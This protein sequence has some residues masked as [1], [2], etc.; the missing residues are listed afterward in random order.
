MKFP[1]QANEGNGYSINRSYLNLPQEFKPKTF[2][3]L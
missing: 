3:L 1:K 2:N